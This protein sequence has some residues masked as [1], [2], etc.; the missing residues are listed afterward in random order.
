MS[1]HL[2]RRTGGSLHDT[3]PSAARNEQ[4]E[5]AR[6]V[7]EGWTT[8]P[9]PADAFQ[10]NARDRDWV[11][12]QSAL[13]PR[14]AFNRLS[15][16]RERST[17][18]NLLPIFWRPDGDL[19]VS[20]V[21]RPCESPG[22]GRRSPWHAVTIVMLDQPEELSQQLQA[23]SSR[24]APRGI[25]CNWRNSDQHREASMN[26]CA[27]AFSPNKRI[28]FSFRIKGRTSS[29]ID[30]FWKSASHRSGEIKG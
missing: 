11:D 28:A 1:T 24:S 6:R 12:R 17:G 7:E 5:P 15:V 4:I 8:P 22:D 13:H 25:S 23:T 26:R 18:S 10:V 3:L 19:T 9:T 14:R 29:R 30:S 2:F 20:A 27:Q 16:L 21:L